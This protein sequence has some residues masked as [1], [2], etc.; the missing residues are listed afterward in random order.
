VRVGQRVQPAD[1]V[2]V[3]TQPGAVVPVN[4]AH[5]L[6]LIPEEVP[7]VLVKQVGEEVQAGEVLARTQGLFGLLRSE[8]LAPCGGKVVSVSEH[9]G[10]V[11]IEA[12]PEPLHVSAFIAG[13][14]VTVVPD[15]GAVVKTTGTCLQGIFGVGG[16]CW[17]E[18]V[19]ALA[20]PE[21][22]LTARQIHSGLKNKVVVGGA[23]VT[24]DALDQA[25]NHEIAALVTGG[26]HG[27]TLRDFLGFD[28]T[29][30]ITGN[31]DI[32]LTLVVT[33]GFGEVAMARRTFAVLRERENALASVN[34]ATQIRAGV[35]RPEIIVPQL[36][37]AGETSP[38][39]PAAAVDRQSPD[40]Q[41]AAD[42]PV[43]LAVGSRVRVICAPYFG[44][45]GRVVAIPDRAVELP[46][47]CR[48]RVAN[49]QFADAQTA[50][51]A[52]ANL[53]I[54]A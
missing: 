6:A 5:N 47:G 23:D 36:L 3:A 17:G 24:L 54:V 11:L 42:F 33:E 45:E 8:C 44:R 43:P 34:G 37:S 12:T 22:V 9:T 51:V 4:V 20:G 1:V 38:D 53:V 29:G 15:Y 21:S 52:R 49:V 39:Q 32:P 18:L 7:G 26:I 14:I 13:E 27:R 50:V 2:A 10:Q 28:L 35:V 48:A 25:V 16:E 41:E 19:L 31:E 30:G 40:A 46:S